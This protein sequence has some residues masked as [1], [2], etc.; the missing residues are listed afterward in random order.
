ME[1]QQGGWN[2]GE[3]GGTMVRQVGRQESGG[4]VRGQATGGGEKRRWHN[5]APVLRGQRGLG[6]TTYIEGGISERAGG[7]VRG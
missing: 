4:Q 6:Y 2:N 5:L 3:A 1:Q 7:Q